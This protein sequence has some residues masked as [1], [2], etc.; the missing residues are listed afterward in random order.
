MFTEVSEERT[1]SIF[2]VEETM[3]YHITFV[4]TA[5]RATVL[6]YYLASGGSRMFR[7]TPEM[8]PVLFSGTSVNI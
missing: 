8:E 4:L 2:K 3:C 7:F 1:A 5:L 6:H